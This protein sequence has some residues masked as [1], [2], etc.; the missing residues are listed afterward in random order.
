MVAAVV[1]AAEVA[2]PAVEAVA[3]AAEVAVPAVAA[4]VVAAGKA[5]KRH[6]PRTEINDMRRS[7]LLSSLA[8]LSVCLGATGPASATSDVPLLRA[9]GVST[10]DSARLDPEQRASRRYAIVIGNNDYE[11]VNDLENAESDAK[12]MARFLRGHGFRVFERYNLDKRGFEDLFSKVLVDVD[13]D[14]EILFYYA[15]H[16]M[17]MGRRNY[18][19]PVDAELKSP[20]DAP[21]ETVTLDSVL[22][23]LAARSR[24]QLVI[25]DSCRD[26]PFA[27]TK[28]MTGMDSRLFESQDGFETVSAPFNTF[29]AYSTSP[30]EV[31]LDGTEGNSVFTG[32]FVKMASARPQDNIARILSDVRREVYEQ[33]KGQQVPW[34]SSTLVEPFQFSVDSDGEAALTGTSGGGTGRPRSVYFITRPTHK[35]RQR[36]ITEESGDVQLAFSAPLERHIALGSGLY[37]PAVISDADSVTV[38]GD[39]S[40]GHLMID[41]PQPSDYTGSALGKGQVNKLYYEYQPSQRAA[42]ATIDA[43]RVRERFTLRTGDVERTV[44]MTLEPNECDYQAGDWLDPNGVGIARYPNE[45][46]PDVALAACTEAL[47]K[48][49][50]VGRFHYQQGRALQALLRFDE[51]KAAYERARDLDHIRAWYALGDLEAEGDAISGGKSNTAVSDEALRLFGTGVKLGDPY[52]YYALGKQLLRHT[53]N[54]VLE[55]EGFKLLN[56]ALELGHTFAMN[57]LGYHFLAKDT[58]HFDPERALRY[59]RE[60][61]ARGD[62][63]GYNNLGLVYERG[64]GTVVADPKAAYDWYVKAAEGGHPFAAVSVGRLYFSGDLA[65]GA[66]AAKAIDWY[67]EGLSRGVGWGGA[68]ASWIIA[69]RQPEGY[70]PGDAAVRAAK[71]A[72][73]R[74][75]EAAQQARAVLDAL[76]LRAKDAGVQMLL[77]DLGQQ[78]TVD[79]V[80]GPK[81]RAAIE[82]FASTDAERASLN[83]PTERLLTLARAYW[84]RTKFRIDL[85]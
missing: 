65:G 42:A 62:I 64:A 79:G 51:A 7:I 60:S 36:P 54:D 55:Q 53:D 17:Q 81:T 4:E 69:N 33:T 30:G 61:A 8:A 44:E 25:L 12:A 32:A 34:D 58:D 48:S 18:L 59:L 16:G 47:E 77:N 63:Y 43:H 74:D 35:V 41:G 82:P 52:A 24:M 21:F 14:S 27:D 13:Q 31:A 49:P 9:L 83:D 57:E 68:N 11:S 46:D 10:D 75:P 28:Q 23:I 71:A 84:K 19:M 15:G 1:Q 50:R 67:D 39:M 37:D 22:S 20:Y 70:T 38:L 29:L 80:V 73:L 3:P 6:P 45:L 40:R 85:Y 78:I 5:Q 26:N 56:R 66:D 2:A 76:P 72:T